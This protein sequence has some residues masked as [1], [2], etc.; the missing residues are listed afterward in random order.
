[1][2]TNDYCEDALD[3]NELIKAYQNM[4]GEH[5][6]FLNKYHQQQQPR[7]KPPR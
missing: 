3:L 7:S 5:S 4:C 1:L 2:K 6:M